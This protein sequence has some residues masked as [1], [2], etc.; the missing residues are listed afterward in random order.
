MVKNSSRCKNVGSK[1][2]RSIKI[3]LQKEFWLKKYGQRNVGKI[4]LW[5]QK[6]FKENLSAKNLGFQKLL[7]QKIVGPKLLVQTK[8]KASKRLGQKSLVNI[9]SVTVEII[10][11]LSFCGGVGGVGWNITV[12]FVS[13][14][15][16]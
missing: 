7:V 11:T 6:V 12:I 1:K 16:L 3:Q 14:L 15:Q 10:E 4:K 13:N 8:F 9:G 2:F 5:V